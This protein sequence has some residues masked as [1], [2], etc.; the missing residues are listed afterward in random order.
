MTQAWV[1]LAVVA[2]S[3]L[4]GL[5]IF[6]LPEHRRTLRTA[7]N[8]GG[9][10]AKLILVGIMLWNVGRFHDYE[11]RLALL[12]GLDLVLRA[13]E[14]SLLF[15]TLSAVLW[16]V[17][18][19]YAVGYLEDAPH[20]SRFFG[21]FSLCVSATAGI[22]LAGNLFTLF[23]F[24]E[25][26]TL[27]TYPLVIHR[28]TP[29]ALAAGRS[30]LMYTL[31][32]GLLLLLAVA[33]AHVL[34]GPQ[35]FVGAGYLK[36]FAAEHSGTL[37]LLFAALVVGFG[38]KAALVPLHGWLPKA[39]VAPAPVSALLHAVAVVKAG[40]FAIQ[41]VVYEV[42]GI[43]FAATLGVLTP[44]AA[45]ASLTIVYGS[46]R[47]LT[48]DEL[49]K[50]LA[51]STVSQV[52]YI[53]L[54]AAVLGPIS[55]IGGLVHLVHQGLMKITLFFSAGNYA[56]TLGVH[57]V[58]EMDGI[59]R[60]M[61]LTTAAFTVGALGMI[62]VPPVA[63][64]VSKLY[65]GAGAAQAAQWWVIGVLAVSSLLNAMYFLP[66]LHRAWFRPAR[67]PWPEEHGRRRDAKPM[68]LVPVLLT[69]LFSVGVGV[70]AAMPWSPLDWARLIVR[71]EYVGD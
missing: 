48:Q 17:T 15:L 56:E 41:R 33:G 16:A 70:L 69:A 14:L 35:D 32:S 57:H 7:L 11:A 68:L 62:G 55:T 44:L 45:A 20:R 27:V 71:R 67:G 61:P 65:L 25:I 22:A 58:H 3:L 18:T 30:Y 40:A 2:S 38:V 26:L 9:A 6:R 23:V 42:F 43:E 49:K 37:V 19:V 10:A 51:Y 53:V 1:P 60:R 24:Y 54:G 46:L 36:P 64:F 52:S 5:I 59:G 47:A 50:R 29:A 63:G 39:M 28:G 21:F 34:T 4:P 8:F 12:P 13:D 31:P 66:I